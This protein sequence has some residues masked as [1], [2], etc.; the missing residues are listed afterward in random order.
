MSETQTTHPARWPLIILGI[1]DVVSLVLFAMI[2]RQTHAEGLAPQSVLMTAAPFVAAWFIVASVL[3]AY[4]PALLTSPRVMFMQSLVVA[5]A[6][7]GL[8]VFLRAALLQVPV[9]PLFAVVAMPMAALF[10]IAWRMIFIFVYQRSPAGLA[11]AAD[12]PTEAKK[13]TS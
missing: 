10:V 8:G 7:G 9:V 1:G 5:L 11:M 12:T 2:G 3:R 13:K 6:A 4:R